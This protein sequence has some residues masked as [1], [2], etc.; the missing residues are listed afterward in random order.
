MNELEL[1]RLRELRSIYEYSLGICD[2]VDFLQRKKILL[3]KI[4]EFLLEPLNDYE[5][6]KREISNEEMD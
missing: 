6:S 1:K 5:K 2:P 4:A 3:E